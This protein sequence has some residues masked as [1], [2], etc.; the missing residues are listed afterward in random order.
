MIPCRILFKIVPDTNV[1]VAALRSQR[2]ASHRLLRQVDRGQFEINLS[3]PLVLEYEDATKR[4]LKE[5]KL[6][7]RE[8]DDVLDYLL[9]CGNRHLIHYLW[10]PFLPDPKDDMILELAV[11]AACQAI[12]TF[13]VRD[14]TGSDQFGIRI[15]TPQMPLRELGDR[16]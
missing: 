9:A 12:V 1:L 8:I 2:G 5:F 6:S 15:L 11:A 14:F 7:S 10:R 3:V 16:T 13:N 4:L